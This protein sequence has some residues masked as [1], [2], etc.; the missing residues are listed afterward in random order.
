MAMMDDAAFLVSHI[1]N[2]FI[3]SDDTGMCELIIDVDEGF[4]RKDS[5]ERRPSTWHSR[6]NIF[7]SLTSDRKFFTAQ[8]NNTLGLPCNELGCNEPPVTRANFFAPKS[9]TSVSECLITFLA[10][11][12]Q[13]P[14]DLSHSL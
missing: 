9:L 10:D 13:F 6:Y 12:E 14:L 2:S 1:R 5:T 11:Y 4:N 7:T 3:T 8:F